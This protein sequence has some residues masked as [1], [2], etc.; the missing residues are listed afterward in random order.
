MK[1]LGSNDILDPRQAA[2]NEIERILN[3]SNRGEKWRAAY[4][5]FLKA[6]PQARYE[7][8]ATI[9]ECREKREELRTIGNSKFAET[10]GKSGMRLGLSLPTCVW[11]ALTGFDPELNEDV[12]TGADQARQ[13]RTMK[14]LLQTFPEFAIP[15]KW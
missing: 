10:Q 1:A 7:V 13:S 9:R 4:N 12:G 8:Q 6:K 5:F 14:L 11:Y 2:L 3:M 15:E